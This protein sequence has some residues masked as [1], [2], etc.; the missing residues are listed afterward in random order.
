MKPRDS[1]ITTLPEVRSIG[2][3]TP[4]GAAGST[5]G[6]SSALA[7]WL[8]ARHPEEVDRAA[9]S[10]A[11]SCGVSLHVDHDYRFPRDEQGRSLGVV[12]VVRGCRVEGS[13][14]ARAAALRDL[15]RLLEPATVVQLEHWLAELS[16]IVARRPDDEAGETLRV[17]AYVRRLQGFP[18]DVARAALLEHRWRFWPSWAELEEVCRRLGAPR[19]AMIAAL[20]RGD[21]ADAPE[22]RERASPGRIA[23]IIREVWGEERRP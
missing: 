18:A 14:E 1:A 22:R 8:A 5:G 6:S 12:T 10:R 16:V 15:R 11:S 4:P 21:E 7:P 2:T 20:E 19:R 17:A 23:E 13:P 9:V 3:G